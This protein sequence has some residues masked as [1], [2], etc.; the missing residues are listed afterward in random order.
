MMKIKEVANRLGETEQFI[1]TG[2]QNGIFPFGTAEKSNGHYIYTIDE[3]KFNEYLMI[4]KK[5]K[6]LCDVIS[7][8]LEGH[9]RKNVLIRLAE[10]ISKEPNK[11]E[12]E[13]Y[14]DFELQKL[15]GDC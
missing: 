4:I 10:V 1:R 2:L 5:T 8:K 13:K 3:V 7:E 12:L 9:S 6:L 14:I 15:K 11:K